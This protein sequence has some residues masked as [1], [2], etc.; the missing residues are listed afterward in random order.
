MEGKV[1]LDFLK[2]KRQSKFVS[3]RPDINLI[4]Q[5]RCF[6]YIFEYVFV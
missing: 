5:V 4:A 1:L 2:N 3:H 6:C